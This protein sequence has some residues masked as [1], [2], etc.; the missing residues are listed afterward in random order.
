LEKETALYEEEDL[1]RALDI[2]TRSSDRLRRSESPRAAFELACLDVT[3]KALPVDEVVDR[4]EALESRLAGGL[5]P[6]VPEKK[7]PEPV[8]DR[9]TE[10]PRDPIRTTLPTD[11]P[12]RAPKPTPAPSLPET[13]APLP[14]LLPRPPTASLGAGWPRVLAAVAAKKPSLEPFLAAARP[15]MST[16]GALRILCRDDFQ[17]SQ[18]AL[19]LALLT[20]IVQKEVGPIPV[21]CALAP[22]QPAPPSRISSRADAP[23][24]DAEEATND[25][26]D[27]PAPDEEESG[28]E[29]KPPSPAAPPADDIADTSASSAEAEEIAALEPGLKKVL[30]R[31][32]GKLKRLEAAP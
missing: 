20:D 4:L 21:A 18:I 11:L 15:E 27:A 32:P 19:H 24:E 12:K 31:F 25:D 16:E 30:D 1:E 22:V 9:K 8:L 17:R 7:K 29:N 6:A 28:T 10:S 23:M 26:E 2:L 5:P 13:P 14:P 3:R